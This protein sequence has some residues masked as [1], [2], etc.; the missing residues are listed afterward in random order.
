VEGDKTVA[1]ILSLVGT[2]ASSLSG[3]IQIT[4]ETVARVLLG[5]LGS[6][7]IV[8]I[9]FV[10]T[11]LTIIGHF[12][13]IVITKFERVCWYISASLNGY[14]L[15]VMRSVKSRNHQTLYGFSQLNRV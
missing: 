7:G 2:L 3:V 14:S 5:F 12:R 15:S 8:E 11:G 1:G 13:E 10:T 4:F 9:S 6:V